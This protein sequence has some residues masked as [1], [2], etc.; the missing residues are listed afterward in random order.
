MGN[1][2]SCNSEDIEELLGFLRFESFLPKPGTD[3]FLQLRNLMVGYFNNLVCHNRT[4]LYS[5]L[6]RIGIS[7]HEVRALLVLGKENINIGRIIA[8]KILEKQQYYTM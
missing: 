6:N 4:L 8:D 5:T 3:A 2:L 7:Q 1:T